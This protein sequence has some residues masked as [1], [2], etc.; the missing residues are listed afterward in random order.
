VLGFNIKFKGK[1]DKKSVAFVTDS[2]D[3]VMLEL[4]Q[5]PEVSALY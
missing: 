1:D 3:R 5:I 4:A 2:G